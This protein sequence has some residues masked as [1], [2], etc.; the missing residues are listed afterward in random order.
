MKSNY[1][2]DAVSYIV[3]KAH[4]QDDYWGA[5]TGDKD[6]T[7]Y[8][9][10]HG[11]I[12]DFSFNGFAFGLD[13]GELRISYDND[14]QTVYMDDLSHK[15]GKYLIDFNNF[16]CFK[17]GWNGFDSGKV[18]IS[19]YASS[20]TKDSMSFLVTSISQVDLSQENITLTEPTGL[21]ID[22]GAYSETD[23]PHAVVG[24]PYRIFDATPS[25]MYTEERVDVTVKTSYGSNHE[26]NISIQ[27]GC[28]VPQRAVTHTIVYTVTDGFGNTKEYPVPVK[29]D[30]EYPPITFEIE[31]E[32]E[33]VNAE[34]GAWAD[35][36]QIQNAT[37]GNGNLR[38]EIVLKNKTTGKT[39]VVEG[40]SYRFVEQGEYVLIYTVKDYNECAM[41]KE[42]PVVLQ[43]SQ[44]PVF[45]EQPKMPL[46]YIKGA[47]YAVPMINADDFSSGS[48]KKVN[49]S[50][51]VFGDTT[52][53]AV[54]DGYF[55]ADGSQLTLKYTAT[56]A[57]GRVAEKP[58][59]VPVTDVSFMEDYLDASKYFQAVGGEAFLG[60]KIVE[61]I[62]EKVLYFKAT[63]ENAYFK[64]IRELYGE[65]FSFVFNMDA[66]K[67]EYGNVYVRVEDMFDAD[68]CI[69][70]SIIDEGG[71]AFV[72]VN[73]AQ[74]VKTNYKFG[75]NIARG[76]VRLS[77]NMLFI[78][79][80]YIPIS[81][82]A[83]GEA[84]NGFE[85]NVYFTLGLE[86]C[87]GNAQLHVDELNGQSLMYGATDL[88]PSFI[89]PKARCLGE[90]EYGSTLVI[91]PVKALDVF[92]PYV[93][94]TFSV[95]LPSGEFATA[96]DGT[97]LQNVRMDKIYQIKLSDYGRY[98][99]VYNAQTTRGEN[100]IAS[101]NVMC[102]DKVAPEI[103][104][105]T[106]E[107]TGKVGEVLSIPEFSAFDNLSDNEILA[108][109]MFVFIITPGQIQHLYDAT[110]GYIPEKAGVYTIRYYVFDE[111]FNATMVDVVCRVS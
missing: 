29:V 36:P 89:Y 50:V 24:K 15:D 79:N 46:T 108:E 38:E 103:S 32:P 90:K 5:Y 99:F 69:E 94:V 83:N 75:G 3:A 66:D 96:L 88:G 42:I 25:S 4:T 109:R 70:I 106:E 48:L 17:S 87:Y 56:D 71:L 95:K 100:R 86:N 101:E 1:H 102:L 98:K 40:D 43:A 11:Y 49:A 67:S 28:F 14:T 54:T 68:K 76:V 8:N 64:F 10:I 12:S 63:E 30:T 59:T 6:G 23:Y 2:N 53:L 93:V 105:P 27:D 77:G 41:A 55:V 20:Y 7:L 45:E 60:D 80:V 26:L 51:K 16:N 62:N 110:T 85:N 58:Y 31:E 21:D 111:E 33:E 52:E 81:T 39:V 19:A 97:L 107:L 74:A 92:D 34:L 44:K 37:G 47:T 35:I 78:C 22:F 73:G 72:S 65:S 18:R 9:G 91:E 57:Q 13:M 82:Y 104:V 61:N 84:F